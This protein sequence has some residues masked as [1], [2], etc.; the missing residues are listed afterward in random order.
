MG[1]DEAEKQN[2]NFY[3]LDQMAG[4]TN[5]SHCTCMFMVDASSRSGSTTEA[6]RKDLHPSLRNCRDLDQAR[7]RR[8]N[9]SKAYLGWTYHERSR[10]RCR[11]NFSVTSAGDM[12]RDE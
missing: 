10:I 11:P 2:R 6:P 4:D 7:P 5:K 12:A 9:D 3:E 1:I 8:K